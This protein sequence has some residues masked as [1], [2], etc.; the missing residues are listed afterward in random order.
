MNAFTSIHIE[1]PS[2][3]NRKKRVAIKDYL[4]NIRPHLKYL[5]LILN[6]LINGKFNK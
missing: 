6:H 3:G 4:E 1:Y 5:T 2:N